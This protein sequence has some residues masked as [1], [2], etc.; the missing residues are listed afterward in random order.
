MYHRLWNE[1]GIN[2]IDWNILIWC[3]WLTII[4]NIMLQAWWSSK[5]WIN[6]INSNNKGQIFI[7]FSIWNVWKCYHYLDLLVMFNSRNEFSKIS[8]TLAGDLCNWFWIFFSWLSMV[9]KFLTMVI[10]DFFIFSKW[11]SN[12][13]KEFD[14]LY[15]FC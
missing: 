11:S 3:I 13:L 1:L 15:V 14:K 10:S 5:V 2:V 12:E 6:T 8:L 9:H 7:V 4:T